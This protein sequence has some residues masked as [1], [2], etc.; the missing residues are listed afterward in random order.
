MKRIQSSL[1][2][3]F[4]FAKQGGFH[5]GVNPVRDTRVNRK[6]AAPAKTHAYT[7]EDIEAILAILPEPAATAFAVAS[8][9]GLRRGEIE[10]LTFDDYSRWRVA[11]RTQHLE[12]PGVGAKDRGVPVG[13]DAVRTMGKLEQRLDEQ[14]AAHGSSGQCCDSAGGDSKTLPQLASVAEQC[15]RWCARNIALDAEGRSKEPFR[16]VDKGIMAMIGR[17]SAVSEVGPRRRGLHGVVAFIA[18]LGVHLAL[19]I[20]HLSE[21]V[22]RTEY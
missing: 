13:K 11:R 22:P 5:D 15:G 10:G 2:G 14:S 7:L 4:K 19:T 9:T 17:N 18:W 16:Y 20:L 3:I 6:A 8:Y 1:S 12:W 21:C